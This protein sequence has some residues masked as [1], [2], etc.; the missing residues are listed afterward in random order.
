MIALTKSY[1][2][3]ERIVS[4][5]IAGFEWHLLVALSD[6]NEPDIAVAAA[7]EEYRFRIRAGV[8]PT[9]GA[10]PQFAA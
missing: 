2:C 1:Q 5:L 4:T 8:W 3:N 10:H 7:R 9:V 6:W